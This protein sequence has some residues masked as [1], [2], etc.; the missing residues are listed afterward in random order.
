MLIAAPFPS[1]WSSAAAYV[2]GQGVAATDKQKEERRAQL[3]I[4]RK[5]AAK[6][7][8]RMANHNMHVA[9]GT[10][11]AFAKEARRLEAVGRRVAARW[12]LATVV[13]CLEKWREMVAGRK[14]A[15]RW[16]QL[17]ARKTE[18]G[19]LRKGLEGWLSGLRRLD[20]ADREGAA[21]EV[22]AASQSET[23]ALHA[24]I[25]EL[26]TALQA[27][28]TLEGELGAVR[29]HNKVLMDRAL[30][31]FQKYVE[32]ALL[33]LLL[34]LLLP[35]LLLLL[36]LLPLQQLLPT[37][38]PPGTSSCGRARPRPEPSSP[39]SSTGRRPGSTC[40]PASSSAGAC[41]GAF[42]SRACGRGARQR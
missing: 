31:G 2:T 39:S 15:R 8:G 12:R 5:R 3:E 29:A 21:A 42:S 1:R 10:W 41:S 25:G 22:E 16:M 7:M 36:F 14:R 28:V 20:M 23:K 18:I 34:L 33:L 17:A 26:E 32:R 4:E 27:I 37:K 40:G 30:K 38:P 19:G 9:F 24:R 13:K 6:V 11:T 35:L